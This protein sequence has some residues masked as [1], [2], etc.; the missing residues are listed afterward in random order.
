[1]LFYV[2]ETV[3]DF[4]MPLPVFP[5]RM[6]ETSIAKVAVI[7]LIRYQMPFDNADWSLSPMFYILPADTFVRYV[8]SKCPSV[9]HD[10]P[11]HQVA[12]ILFRE[13]SRCTYEDLMRTIHRH[14][15]CLLPTTPLDRQVL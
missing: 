5:Y 14:L 9:A 12:R 1:M 6:P 10:N 3:T 7:E 2:V 11:H 15:P 8:T 4:L 13:S